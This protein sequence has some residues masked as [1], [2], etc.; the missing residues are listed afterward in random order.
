MKKKII[1]AV[2]D[3]YDI[4][5]IFTATKRFDMVIYHGSNVVVEHPDVRIRGFEKDFGYL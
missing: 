1:C 3:G 2:C 4:F 5:S